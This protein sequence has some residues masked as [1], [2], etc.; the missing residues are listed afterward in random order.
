MNSLRTMFLAAAVA[1]LSACGQE[2]TIGHDGDVSAADDAALSSAKFETFQGN[3]G[4]FYFHLIAGNGQKVLASQ[5]Y[6]TK[7][8]ANDGI[9][10]VKANSADTSRYFMREASDGSWYF[11]VIAG[12]GQIIAMS[13]MYS[14]QSN[15]TR[16]MTTV[17]ALVK[18]TTSPTS[19]PTGTARF[20][21]FKGL[22]GK[23]YFHVQAANG[24]IVMQSQAYTTKASANNGVASVQTNGVQ[25]SRYEVLAAADGQWFFHL[26]AANGQI[27]AHGETYPTQSAAIAGRDNC[28]VIRGGTVAR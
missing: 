15:A 1:T 2:A 19:A 10:S 11:V 26:K 4:R 16:G 27:I 5:G 8:S 24:E 14:T 13:E 22:D 20:A 12:N 17:Q 25:T 6:S 28:T 3:D 9:A 18:L 23:Y 7:S 21:V